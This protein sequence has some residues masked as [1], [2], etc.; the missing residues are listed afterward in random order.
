MWTDR[1]MNALIRLAKPLI[2]AA[3]FA[4]PAK[5]HEFWLEPNG[6]AHAPGDK[7]ELRLRNGD[8]FKGSAYPWIDRY[9]AGAAVYDR[10][11]AA[12]IRGRNGDNPALKFEAKAGGLH[13]VR[14]DSG[15]YTLTYANWEKFQTFI[16]SKP[17]LAWVYE[18]HEK[19]NFP[20]DGVKESYYRYPKALIKVGS[21]AG[22]DKVLGAPIEFVAEINPYSEA[23]KDGVRVRLLYEG[24]PF[25]N[26]DVQIFHTPNGA[27][28]PVKDHVTT[29]ATG[30]AV[31][32]VFDG[33]VILI[34]ATHMREPRPE[35]AAAG[36]MW[37]SIW[38][39]MTYELPRREAE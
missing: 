21:G 25:P 10:R 29:D 22:R 24:E 11:G 20:E 19:R 6:Y 16:D 13:I 15:M 33:G 39:S 35:G 18:E 2:A 4:L 17:N 7:V 26:I 14:F 1:F 28:N 37:E 31:I 8:M 5:A 32:P 12:E 27:E 30:R 34:N 23:A 38:A 36:M 3:F 9:V